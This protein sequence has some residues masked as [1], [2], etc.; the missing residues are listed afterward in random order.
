MVDT[1]AVILVTGAAGK[2]G[3]AF[4]RRLLSDPAFAHF[5][6]RALCHN[7]PLPAQPRLEVMHGD[8]SQQETARRCMQ[9]VTHV[10]HMAHVKESP[11]LVMDVAVKGLFWL[12]EEARSSAAFRQFILIGGDNAVGHCIVP[13]AAPVTEAMGHSPYPGCYALAKVLE[14]VMLEQYYT[15]YDLNGCCLRAPWIM[16]K[17]DF[18]YTL[19]FGEDVFGGPRWRDLVGAE[20]ADR[21][22]QAGTVPILCDADGAPV[23]RNFVHVEDLVSAI[24]AAIGNPK[25]RQQTFNICMDEPVDYA[26]MAEY[27]R[28][29]RGLPSV[30][31]RTSCYSNWLDNTKAKFLLG[32][33]PVYDLHRLID[34]AWAYQR[35][36][37]DPRKVWYPG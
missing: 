8:L 18:K 4:L 25:A 24:L 16:E 10:V 35:V 11:E 21:Y 32:W 7:R 29:T 3:Q 15:Q 13:H 12:L 30:A 19:S 36:P 26:E 34:A 28:Q 23:Q 1:P 33:R 31:I 37:D 9:G 14:E 27:L 6:V 22:A 17:D 2:V 20:L 5:T